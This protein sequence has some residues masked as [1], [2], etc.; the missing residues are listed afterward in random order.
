MIQHFGDQFFRYAH[1]DGELKKIKYDVQPNVV[2]QGL[3][4]FHKTV[5]LLGIE[6]YYDRHEISKWNSR[7]R[8]EDDLQAQSGLI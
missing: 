7:I 4:D 2:F 8:F 5:S 6:I 3:T 1:L